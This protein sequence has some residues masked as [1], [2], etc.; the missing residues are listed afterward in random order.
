MHAVSSPEG[1]T[2]AMHTR[3][4]NRYG[5]GVPLFTTSSLAVGMANDSLQE[6][7]VFE[8]EYD[9]LIWCVTNACRILCTDRITM[10]VCKSFES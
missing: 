2:F 7:R 3:L 10:L 6:Y 4:G 9:G 1:G 8:I 5:F